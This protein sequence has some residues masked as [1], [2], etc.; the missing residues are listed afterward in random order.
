[1]K[2]RNS[3]SPDEK[4]E[5]QMTPMIDI[6]FQLLIFFIMTFKVVLREGDFGVKM[7][8]ASTNQT[9]LP[10]STLPIR[11]K[12]VAGLEGKLTDVIIDDNDNL[13]RESG[14]RNGMLEALT[15]RIVARKNSSNV[16]DF[17]AET[18]VE[19]DADYDLAYEEQI[20]AITAISGYYDSNG[21]PVP[22][23]EKIKFKDSSAGRAQ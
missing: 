15:A 19:F 1:M 12:L 2:V 11:I 17:A 7:P 18:E 8:L 10:D 4:I 13:S 3:G 23:I 5:L 20:R 6:V 16:G 21:N 9:A 22:L 14:T